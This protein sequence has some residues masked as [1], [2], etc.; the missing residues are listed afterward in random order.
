MEDATAHLPPLHP[1]AFRLQDDV[2]KLLLQF[3]DAGG[4][5]GFPS[6][7]SALFLLPVQRVDHLQ[8]QLV[9][10]RYFP[11]FARTCEIAL[12]RSAPV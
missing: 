3:C 1:H 6:C 11:L 10:M 9:Q 2:P 7:F 12:L 5:S 8:R 4:V